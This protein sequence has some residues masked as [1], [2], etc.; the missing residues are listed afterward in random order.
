MNTDSFNNSVIVGPGV[1]FFM[2]TMAIVAVTDPLKESFIV[3]VNTLC[4]AFRC[5]T[6]QQHFRKFIDTRPFKEYWN[7]VDNQGR[8]IGFFRWTWEL[9]NQVNKFLSKYQPSLEEAYKYYSDTGAGICTTCGG[10]PPSTVALQQTYTLGKLPQMGVI[11]PAFTLG[12]LATE[13]VVDKP[14]VS[15]IQENNVTQRKDLQGPVSQILTLNRQGMI[16]LPFG[17]PFRLIS[18]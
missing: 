8:D 12:K 7:I 14:I 10:H 1:W 13:H 2:H 18:R 6:C 15:S 5:K 11:T 16:P 3:Y 4:D 9:H 17:P